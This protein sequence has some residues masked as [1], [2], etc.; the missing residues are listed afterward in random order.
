MNKLPAAIRLI[1]PRPAQGLHVILFVETEDA[2]ADQTW[3]RATDLGWPAGTLLYALVADEARDITRWFGI[4]RFPALAAV[5]DG[6]LVA[7]EEGC[8]QGCAE[9]LL[10]HA[11]HAAALLSGV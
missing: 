4:S 10:G 9:R 7:L 6:S 1:P 5:L 3:R 2:S 8:E 11:R